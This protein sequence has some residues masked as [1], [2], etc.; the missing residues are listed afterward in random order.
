MLH[1]QRAGNLFL[2]GIEQDGH[3]FKREIHL[4]HNWLRIRGEVINTAMP[5]NQAAID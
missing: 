4:F 1:T 5:L 2:L 3:H